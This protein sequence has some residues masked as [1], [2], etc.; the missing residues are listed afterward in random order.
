MQSE[1]VNIYVGIILPSWCLLLCPIPLKKGEIL[2]I[3]VPLPRGDLG[4]SL[5][6]L[7]LLSL[8]SLDIVEYTVL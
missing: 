6:D 2:C 7:V 8:A 3:R 5:G 4:L 1:L